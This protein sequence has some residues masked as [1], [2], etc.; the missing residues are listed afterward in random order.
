VWEYPYI[1][2]KK[3]SGRKTMFVIILGKVYLL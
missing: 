1:G 3:E 2:P